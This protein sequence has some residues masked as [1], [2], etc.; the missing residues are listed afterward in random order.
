MENKSVF[1]LSLMLFLFFSTDSLAQK[2]TKIVI[3]NHEL[4]TVITPG[5]NGTPAAKSI[6]SGE[7]LNVI[8][9]LAP[10]ISTA[11]VITKSI[12]NKLKKVTI[13]VNGVPL[14]LVYQLPEVGSHVQHGKTIFAPI[15][16][17]VIHSKSTPSLPPRFKDD[18][19]FNIRYLD[20]VQGMPSSYI[21]TIYQDSKD[22]IWFGTYG[23]G[24][25]RYDGQSFTTFTEKEGLANNYV[26]SITEDSKGH[27]WFATWGGGVTRYDGQSFTTF[28]EKEG[29]ASNV[30]FSIIE[31]KKGN[32]WF[33][34]RE[35]GVSYYDG[36]S[37]TT[38]TT[39]HGLANNSIR[40]IIEDK[41][42][43]IWL[44]TNG[45]GISYYDGKSF[46]YP[47]NQAG[48]SK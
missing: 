38:F 8:N 36:H 31:D 46:F 24:V 2:P 17:A 4:L 19:V 28:S 1:C 18:T 47:F 32:M 13:G 33:G 23:G 21:Y 40:S 43:N 15:A 44:G 35:G 45:G 27:F 5:E 16:K 10:K 7:A 11:P 41:K 3:V 26:Y 22:N 29:L 25:T 9:R 37:F 30:V 34:T 39:K 14:P 48:P 20:V 12:Q 6:V 42:G